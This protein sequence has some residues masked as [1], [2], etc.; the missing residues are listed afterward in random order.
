[1]HGRKGEAEVVIGGA[2]GLAGRPRQEALPEGVTVPAL[3]LLF[4]PLSSPLPLGEDERLAPSGPKGIEFVR[5]LDLERDRYL[6][7]HRLDGKP[8]LPFAFAME[9]MAEVAA[10]SQPSLEVV[11]V[12][13]QRLLKGIVVEGEQ[14]ICV[15]AKPRASDKNGASGVCVDVAIHSLG[16]AVRAHYRALVELTPAIEATAAP[17]AVRLPARLKRMPLT[18]REAYEQWLFHGPL[19][20]RILSVEGFE[21]VGTRATL[22]PSSPAGCLTGFGGGGWL[23][24][25][26]LVDAAFQMQV[27]WARH[28]WDVTLLPSSVLSYRR[29][30]RMGDMD[31]PIRHEMVIRPESRPP[32]CRADHYFYDANGRLL[33]S[34]ADV[35][36]TGARALNRLAQAE[37]TAV[38]QR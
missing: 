1:R 11:E 19:F 16:A 15:R 14:P 37:P 36:G 13:Q 34:I 9:L 12:R 38:A 4:S 20:Q 29:F 30:A 21:P 24:D 7:D 5:T 31:G 26:I 22:L 6:L 18:V 33:M 32:T 23:F 35:E 2:S 25:P 8:V 17:P 10:A 3:P 28:H 27:I